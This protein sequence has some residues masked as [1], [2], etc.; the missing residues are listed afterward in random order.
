MADWD[1]P[2]ATTRFGVSD[3]STLLAAASFTSLPAW[4]KMSNE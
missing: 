3:P 1:S 4:E 2:T